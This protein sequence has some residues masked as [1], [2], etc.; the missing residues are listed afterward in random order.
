MRRAAISVPGRL[1]HRAM[2]RAAA[3]VS[4]GPAMNSPMMINAKLVTNAWISPRIEAGCPCASQKPSSA[5]PRSSGTTRQ[6]PGALGVTRRVT[7]SGEMFTRRSASR[8]ATAAATDTPAATTMT[9][10][11]LPA[12][13]RLSRRPPAGSAGPTLRAQRRGA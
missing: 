13:A 6:A 4:H 10:K 7:P 3:M 5:R 1:V 8:A 9:S 2:S 12:T 11:E